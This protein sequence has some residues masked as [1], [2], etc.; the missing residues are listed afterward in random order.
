MLSKIFRTTILTSALLFAPA[1][2]YTERNAIAQA[3]TLTTES[4]QSITLTNPVNK[5]LG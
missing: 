2:S 3:A 1:I 5:D 4:S